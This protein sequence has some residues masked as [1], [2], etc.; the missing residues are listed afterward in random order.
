MTILDAVRA[1]AAGEQEEALELL[2]PPARAKILVLRPGEDRDAE[3]SAYV[4][5]HGHL[6]LDVVNLVDVDRFVKRVWGVKD[7]NPPLVHI[8]DLTGWQFPYEGFPKEV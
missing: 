3:V 4:E 7:G 8:I 1:L 2:A 6:P 5:R